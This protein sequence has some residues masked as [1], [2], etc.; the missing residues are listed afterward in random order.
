MPASSS[1]RNLLIGMLALR[2]DFIDRDQMVAAMNVWVLDKSKPLEQILLESG[3]LHEDTHALLVQVTAKHLELHDGKAQQSLQRIAP[4]QTLK[5]ELASIEDQDVATSVGN[6]TVSLDMSDVEQTRQM[7]AGTA[8]TGR[9]LC[10]TRRATKSR[11]CTQA[12]PAAVC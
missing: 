2:M 11:S 4:G 6:L 8:A 3:A 10:G 5:E 7:S 1:D 9:S 12:N